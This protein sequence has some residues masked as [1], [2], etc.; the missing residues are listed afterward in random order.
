MI[1]EC[2]VR[3]DIACAPRL[4]T[5]QLCAHSGGE[6]TRP[7]PHLPKQKQQQGIAPTA[8]APT[9]NTHSI[10]EGPVCGQAVGCGV[11]DDTPELWRGAA[12]LC[13]CVRACANATESLH[14][15]IHATTHA[16]TKEHTLTRA[17]RWA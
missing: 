14:A 3:S 1:N 4:A 17:R 16:A 12:G 2:A 11:C 6:G 8:R 13:A 7:S 5:T 10:T 15:Y 9:P